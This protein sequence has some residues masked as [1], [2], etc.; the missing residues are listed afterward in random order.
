MSGSRSR[1]GRYMRKLDE[2]IDR[3]TGPQ[4]VGTRK[5]KVKAKD[6]QDNE[7]EVEVEEPILAPPSAADD[8]KAIQAM[9]RASKFLGLDVPTKSM[10]LQDRVIH[11]DPVAQKELLDADPVV[12]QHLLAI[13]ARRR[14]L[15]F[16]NDGRGGLGN[17]HQPVRL[18]LD[19]GSHWRRS[20]AA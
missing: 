5:V 4:Q 19:S 10:S 17:S 2:I 3:R 16:A 20:I 6:E 13:N 8:G 15:A 9:D 11:I 1:P 18:A 12:Q 14:E 7:I